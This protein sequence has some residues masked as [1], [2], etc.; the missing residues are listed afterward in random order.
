MGTGIGI[1]AS[2][3]A[4][5]EVKFVEPNKSGQKDLLI[6][7]QAGAIKRYRKSV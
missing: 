5:L 7:F 2:R 1:V 6:L 3:V 4:G